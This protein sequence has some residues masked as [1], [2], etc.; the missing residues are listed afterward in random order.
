VLMRK[1]IGWFEIFLIAATSRSVNGA[2][3]ESN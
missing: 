2:N 3:C 1:R